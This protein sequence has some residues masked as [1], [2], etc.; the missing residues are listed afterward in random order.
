MAV[1]LSNTDFT[2]DD[3]S[4]VTSKSF[5]GLSVGVAAADRLVFVTA[6]VSS[7]A[8]SVQPSI[9]A[10]TIGGVSAVSPVSQN[11]PGGATERGQA[12]IWWALVPTGTTATVV[13]TLNSVASTDIILTVYRVVGAD[14]TTPVASTASTSSTGTQAIS[15]ALTIPSNGA[16]IGWVAD[17]RVSSGSFTWTNLTEDTD[18]GGTTNSYNASSASSS[19]AAA[20]TR[21]ATYVAS[22]PSLELMLVMVAINVPGSITNKTVAVTQAKTAT[23]RRNSKKLISIAQAKTAAVRR[24]VAKIVTIA[25]AKTAAL[26]SAIT[27]RLAI[28]QAKVASIVPAAVRPKLLSITQVKVAVLV[29]VYAKNQFINIAQS[30]VATLG[31]RQINRFITVTQAK[32]ATLRKAINHGVIS[33][34]QAKVARLFSGVGKRIAVSQIKVAILQPP[35][36][37]RIIRVTQAKTATLRRSMERTLRIT[38]GKA[39]A[40]IVRYAKNI[41]ITVH[42]AKVATLRAR[43]QT[44]AQALQ[45]LKNIITRQRIRKNVKTRIRMLKNIITRRIP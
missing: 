14:T 21:T 10:A 23:L 25:Q 6:Y 20:L 32:A 13:F 27:R 9:S 40:I 4:S 41:T 11:A 43:A 16:G 2:T 38:Q 30:K 37:S 24:N 3:A 34:T 17:L 18:Q 36:S 7:A 15:A 22:I 19:S 45:M 29:R 33:I 42:Q 44:P 5:A 1:T 39:A 26:R 12:S 8:A 35:V 31:V 28:T